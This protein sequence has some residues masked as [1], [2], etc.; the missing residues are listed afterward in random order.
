MFR[1]RDPNVLR[2]EARLPWLVRLRF[3]LA[4]RSDG[5]RGLPEV[6]DDTVSLSPVLD[7]L[8]RQHDRVLA[9]LVDDQLAAD[10]EVR[11]TLAALTDERGELTRARQRLEEMRRRRDQVLAA[12]VDPARRRGEQTL[13]AETVLLRRNREYWHRVHHARKRVEDEVTAVVQHDK[14]TRRLDEQLR[15]ATMRLDSRARALGGRRQ[16]QATA[17]LSGAIRTHPDPQALSRHQGLLRPDNRWLSSRFEVDAAT[18]DR[19]ALRPLAE[20]S[21]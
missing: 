4:G 19:S 1:R 12:G 5:R 20:A 11:V 16:A 13:S 6:T 9:R 8:A 3:W 7:S 15:I 10:A 2:D 17:Y 18:P 14:Q 21:S